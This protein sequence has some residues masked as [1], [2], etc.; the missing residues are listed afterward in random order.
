M[1]AD[2]SFFSLSDISFLSFTYFTEVGMRYMDFLNKTIRY[3]IYLL[4]YSY[5][6]Q[7]IPPYENL[8]N[9]KNKKI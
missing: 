1:L 8:K 4:K 6:I 7:G 9:K 5:Q 2:K 3:L